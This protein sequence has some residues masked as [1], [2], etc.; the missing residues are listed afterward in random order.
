MG[1]GG[2]APEL[3][4]WPSSLL[5]LSLDAKGKAKKENRLWAILRYLLP[6]LLKPLMFALRYLRYLRLPKV[7]TVEVPYELQ[8]AAE[9]AHPQFTLPKVP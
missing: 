9:T 5:A 1:G 7:C 8:S 4:D 6:T 3:C 2:G